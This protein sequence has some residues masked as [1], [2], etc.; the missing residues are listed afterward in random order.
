MTKKILTVL[1]TAGV[2]ALGVTGV[3]YAQRGEAKADTTT[4]M[5]GMHGM[6]DMSAMMGMMHDCPMMQG[7]AQGPAAALKH[8][9]SLALSDAQVQKLEAIRVRAAEARS[10][11]MERMKAL[12][13]EI[14]AV[15]GADR[16]DEAAVRRAFTQ[17]GTA[18]TEMGVA[19]LRFR[20]ETRET[21]TPEQRE[22][23]ARLGGGMM[24]MQGMSGMAEMMGGDMGGM[25]GM[26]QACPMMQEMQ[27]MM[28][29]GMGGMHM[30]RP[31]STPMP[32]NNRN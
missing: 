16:F 22:K 13:G 30:Q 21:L 12:H 9:D 2:A 31:D 3:G 8:R 7:M 11:A 20:H 14:A 17:M 29:G 10:G 26:M 1:A 4:E 5:R 6:S 27:G 18:H 32:R 15:A 28:Q 25:M 19:M 23:L 24:G